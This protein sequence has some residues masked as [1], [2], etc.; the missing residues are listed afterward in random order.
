[1]I[2]ALFAVS[3]C[4]GEEPFDVM[5]AQRRLSGKWDCVECTGKTYQMNVSPSG[6]MNVHYSNLRDLGDEE[7]VNVILLNE[8]ELLVPPQ[9]KI[10]YHIEGTGTIS[11]EYSKVVLELSFIDLAHG[12]N[13]A[14]DIVV[15][16]AKSTGSE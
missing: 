12:N 5:E 11:D 10:S 8:E 2:F 13:E 6:V 4:G 15:T 1:M 16:C 9:E 7:T 3:A 14:Q